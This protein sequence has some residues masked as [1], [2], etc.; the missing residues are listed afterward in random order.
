MTTGGNKMGVGLP[1]AA[2]G[3]ARNSAAALGLAGVVWQMV[4]LLGCESP[5]REGDAR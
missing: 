2:S 3:R 5:V 4:L 1:H